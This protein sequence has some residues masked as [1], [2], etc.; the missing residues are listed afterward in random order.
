[1]TPPRRFLLGAIALVTAVVSAA[2][3]TEATLEAAVHNPARSAKFVARDS[4]R[5]PLEELEFFG[6]TPSSTVVEIWPGG[7]YWTEILAPFLHERGVYYVA[8]AGKGATAEANQEAEK[9][10]AAFRQKIGADPGIYSKVMITKLGLGETD[11]APEGSADVVLTFRNLHNWLAEGD[12]PETLA[13][14]R[15]D[16]VIAF[17]GQSLH[18]EPHSVRWAGIVADVVPLSDYW[19]DPRFD[20]KKPGRSQGL[21]DNIYRPTADGLEQVQN[22]THQPGDRNKDIGGLNSLVFGDVWYFGAAA[23]ILPVHFGLRMPENARRGHR[24]SK[25]EQASWSDLKAWLDEGPA[26]TPTTNVISSGG[27]VS[28]RAPE[29]GRDPRRE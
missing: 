16:L 5:H 7:G 20:Q 10:N 28:T 24:R 2:A 6:V 3:A 21:P 23:P 29:V 8:L 18:P 19:D 12:A 14:R 11:I 26:Q 13:A 17:N 27:C 15:G 9:Y 1:M 22:A 25:I 4:V